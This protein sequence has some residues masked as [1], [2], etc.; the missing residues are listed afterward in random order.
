MLVVF[1][2]NIFS[3]IDFFHGISPFE[4]IFRRAPKVHLVATRNP[5]RL[6]GDM[7]DVKTRHRTAS[8]N[9]YRL[10][11]R[12]LHNSLSNHLRHILECIRRVEEDVTEG[13]DRFGKSQTLQDTVLRNLQDEC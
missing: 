8:H 4:N 9:S 13:P 10:P 11:V 6:T 3:N 1:A 5:H 12:H 2:E 7:P